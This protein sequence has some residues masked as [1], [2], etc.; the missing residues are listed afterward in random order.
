MKTVAAAWEFESSSGK[1]TYETLQYSDGTTSCNC[2]GWTRRVDV[3][4]E[5]SCKH[6]RSVDMGTADVNAISHVNYIETRP[7]RK[8]IRDKAPLA[9]LGT[10]QRRRIMMG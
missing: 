6:T 5:R 9:D 7:I 2:P 4:G 3:N 10:V 1:K 8:P